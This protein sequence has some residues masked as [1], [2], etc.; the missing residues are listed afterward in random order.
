[1]FDK[2]AW[3][4][5]W[6]AENKER[7]TGYHIAA[8]RR[9]PEK[10]KAAHNKWRDANVQK[11]NDATSQWRGRNK[12]KLLAYSRDYAARNRAS[13][14]ANQAKRRALKLLATPLWADHELIE[15]I[16]AEAAHRG[17]EVDH[18]IPLQGKTVCGLHVHTNMQL[19][20]AGE[21]YSKRNKYPYPSRIPL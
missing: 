3:Q 11:A 6:R 1:M 17:L 13:R 15:L 4:R 7:N 16:Y 12:E 2:I 10:H 8:Y 14:A 9:D 18:V 5:Q 21:N 20:S 19:L